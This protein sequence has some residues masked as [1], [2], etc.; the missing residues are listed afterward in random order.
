M[1]HINRIRSGPF[2]SPDI[3]RA[4]REKGAIVSN[5][6]VP[7]LARIVNVEVTPQQEIVRTYEPVS[8]EEFRAHYKNSLYTRGDD[9]SDEDWQRTEIQNLVYEL[10]QDSWHQGVPASE[11]I[12]CSN[13][14]EERPAHGANRYDEILLCNKCVE[15][16][17]LDYARA[18]VH[19]AQEWVALGARV[20]A[21]QKAIR[22]CQA[23]GHVIHALADGRY[24]DAYALYIR[25]AGNPYHHEEFREAH[26][27]EGLSPSKYQVYIRA[28]LSEVSDCEQ[29][30]IVTDQYKLGTL[31]AE[32]VDALCALL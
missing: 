1:N 2:Q 24:A 15:R 8:V 4:L 23:T 18:K 14:T 3:Q 5:S 7:Y 22:K 6:E 11:T 26:W 10:A 29:E 25:D 9:E 13:C 28:D 30:I 12:Y 20:V 31:F 19:S 16:Y 17:E 27:P 32:G 21:A